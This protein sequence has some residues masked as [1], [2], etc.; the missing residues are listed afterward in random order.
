MKLRKIVAAAAL[1]AASATA[2]SAATYNLGDATYGA[3][4]TETLI[5]Q[6]LDFIEFSFDAPAGYY[7]SALDISVTS[8]PGSNFRELIGLYSGSS[9]VATAQSPAAGSSAILS[10]SGAA[11]PA[12]G[13]YTLA[14]GGWKSYFTADIANAYSTAFFNN[15]QYS[16]NINPTLSAV[17]LPA[18]G[19]LLLTGFGAMAI[20]RRK[21]RSA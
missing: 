6:T 20:A 21:K 2:G 8:V 17:P 12:E 14:I 11:V 3:T 10:F 16:V 9:L 7:V 13:A 4:T 18:G 1:V 19:L 15:G 5:K